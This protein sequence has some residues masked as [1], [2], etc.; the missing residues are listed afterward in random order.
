MY[1]ENNSPLSM[2]HVSWPSYQMSQIPFLKDNQATIAQAIRDRL[3]PQVKQFDTQICWINEKTAF[4]EIVFM[5]KNTKDMI[6][7]ANTK[8][9]GGESILKILLSM[10]GFKYYPQ[11]KS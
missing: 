7:D 3:T 6:E 9:H 5:Y 8:P 10:M 11:P 2:V 4:G 1:M